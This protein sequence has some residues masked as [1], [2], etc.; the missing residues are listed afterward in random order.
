MITR[1]PRRFEDARY[2]VIVVGGGI[3]GAMV[4]REASRL[5]RSAL[6][7]ERDDFGAATSWNSLRIVHGGLRYLQTADIRR[8]RRSV[9]ERRRFLR[10][11][12]D[13]VR[14]LRCVMPL[15]GEPLRHPLLLRA[16]LAASD[17]LSVDRNSGV[18]EDRRIPRGRIVSRAE[19]PRSIT[20][21]TRDDLR[22]GA[23][24]Y[25]AAMESS[26]RVLIETIRRACGVGGRALNYVEATELLVRDG[27]VAGVRATDRRSGSA[28]EYRSAAVVNC[29]GPWCRELAAR[30]H[31]DRPDLFRPS[32]AFNVLLR[33]PPPAETALAVPAGGT[34]G[35]YIVY[36]HAAGTL[37]GTHHVPVPPGVTEAEPADRD[38]ERFVADLRASLPAWDVDPSDVVN[39]FAGLLPARED[40]TVDL[41]TRP[42]VVR[43]DR[44]GGPVGLVSVSGVKFTTARWVARRALEAANGVVDRP[45]GAGSPP[46]SGEGVATRP[47]LRF[48]E[49]RELAEGDREAARRHV[50]RIAREESVTCP[51]DL[52]YRRTAW[53]LAPREASEALGLVAELLDPPPTA[54]SSS[55][56]GGG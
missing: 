20:R 29:A 10:R 38:I 19:L 42:L 51:E 30:F 31:T 14:P 13:L 39:V 40:G 35:T 21:A 50:T 43:H 2:D 7:V 53:G 49:F 55:P 36:P 27:A 28:L 23:E 4:L 45:P 25:D 8:F 56:G 47:Y 26:E 17:L 34:N 12:P 22:G 18:R 3:Y 15:A 37:A 9:R 46:S 33:R 48:S 11:Y 32:L 16:A 24:W 41:R 54:R 52:V 6:L 5:G 44:L 1:D